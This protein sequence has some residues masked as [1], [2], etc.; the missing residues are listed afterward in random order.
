MTN[1]TQLLK[2]G[3]VAKVLSVSRALAYQWM[4]R[5][6]L[7]VFRVPGSRSVRVPKAALDKWIERQT[8][9]PEAGR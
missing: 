9:E 6:I 5:G 3:E 1:E 2:G 4:A 7:P 8:E